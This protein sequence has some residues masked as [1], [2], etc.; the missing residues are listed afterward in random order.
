[1]RGLSATP[2]KDLIAMQGGENQGDPCEA[3][4]YHGYNGLERDVVARI[5]A[6]IAPS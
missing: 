5:A 6:W 1:M 4:A 3:F 2:R